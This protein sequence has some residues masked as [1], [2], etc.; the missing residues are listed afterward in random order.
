MTSNHSNNSN[1]SIRH[2]K[3]GSSSIEYYNESLN[4]WTPFKIDKDNI[5][6]LTN[7][8]FTQS[9][10]KDIISRDIIKGL[11]YRFEKGAYNPIGWWN[12]IIINKDNFNLLRFP[13]TQ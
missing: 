3:K 13:L 10:L 4:I 2:L 6:Y 1:N 7:D 11:Y 12:P 8:I 5:N 9:Q